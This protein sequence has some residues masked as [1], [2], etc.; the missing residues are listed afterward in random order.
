MA[1]ISAFTRDDLG[2]GNAR[3]LRRD[4]KIPVVLYGGGQDNRHLF[5]DALQFS[6]IMMSEGDA[7]KTRPQNLVVDGKGRGRAVLMRAMTVH[8]L[9]GSAEHV[10]FMRFDPN[11]ELEVEVPFNVVGE[12]ECPGI[13][14][15]GMLQV[16]RHEIEVRCKASAIPE[17]ITASV[18]GLN[19]GDSIHIE[20][21]AIPDGVEVVGEGNFTVAAIVGIQAE[22]EQTAEAE[23]GAEEGAEAEG[24]EAEASSEG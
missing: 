15:G 6:K 18:E 12:E 2:K 3:K 14:I 13:K 1:T 17:E 19:I 16:I 7:L 24:G 5:I 9:S 10:D 22:A 8:P 20:D 23:E 11:M 21:V 4:G